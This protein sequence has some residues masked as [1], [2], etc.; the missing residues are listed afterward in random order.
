MI[1]TPKEL[2]A[3]QKLLQ[4]YADYLKDIEFVK[5]DETSYKFYPKR[6]PWQAP[7][8]CVHLDIYESEYELRNVL[9]HIFW[10][11]LHDTAAR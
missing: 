9:Y 11:T 7:R 1:L 10:G 6:H 5:V 3:R 2:S 4:K 8:G